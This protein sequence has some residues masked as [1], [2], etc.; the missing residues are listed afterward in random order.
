MTADQMFDLLLAR[1]VRDHGG[2]RHRWRKLIGPIRLYSIATHPHCNWTATP[3]G[4]AA[5][6][7]AVERLA[8]ELRLAHPILTT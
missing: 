6:I 7:E 1:L 2:S 5:E 8:D 3:V 4:T